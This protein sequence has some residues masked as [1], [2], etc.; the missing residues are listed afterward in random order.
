MSH[1][2]MEKKRVCAYYTCVRVCLCVSLCVCVCVYVYVSVCLCKIKSDSITWV[3]NMTE[4][5]L[6]CHLRKYYF[7]SK[8]GSD[9]RLG[10]ISVESRVQPLHGGLTVHSKETRYYVRW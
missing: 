2:V 10:R 9:P 1:M 6:K 3:N 8:V 4:C 7:W 5:V